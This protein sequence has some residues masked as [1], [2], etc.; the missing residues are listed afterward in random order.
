MKNL[1]LI[2]LISTSVLSC[3]IAQDVKDSQTSKGVGSIN[4]GDDRKFTAGEI[5]IAKNICSLLKKKR[6]YFQ[7]LQDMKT[8]FK[9][10]ITNVS[11]SGSKTADDDFEAG[12]SNLS[13]ELEYSSDRSDYFRTVVTDQSSGVKFLCDNVNNKEVKNNYVD[14]KVYYLFGVLLHDGYP[15][16]EIV[17]SSIGD[18][19][20]ITPKVSE[21]IEIINS[22]YQGPQQYFGVEK[23]HEKNVLCSNKAISTSEQTWI[24]KVRSFDDESEE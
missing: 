14:G 24:S 9:F 8:V 18:K 20:E 15:R 23:L 4:I 6:E 11:C 13:T 1:L 12:V 2:G 19:G 5:G 16:L 17:K 7:S 3:K 21:A 10:H 22:I